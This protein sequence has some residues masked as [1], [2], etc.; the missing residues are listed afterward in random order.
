MRASV[1]EF[2]EGHKH[3]FITASLAPK[4]IQSTYFKVHMKI[5]FKKL[6]QRETSILSTLSSQ[7][8]CVCIYDNSIIALEQRPLC[9]RSL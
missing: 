8:V 3:Q 4:S 9:P 5:F 1:Y 7:N 6:V 2:V